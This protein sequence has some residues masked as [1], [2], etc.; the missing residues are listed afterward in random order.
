[1]KKI[2][3]FS[4]II[5][6]LGAG[7]LTYMRWVKG[8]DITLWSF[9]PQNSAVVY[10]SSNLLAAFKEIQQTNIWDN[11]S[12]IPEFARLTEDLLQ[13]DTI[14]GRGNFSEF[15]N[16]CPALIAL[17]VTS[18]QTF[19]FLYIL[20]IQNLSQQTYI[21]KAQAYFEKRGYKKQTREYEDFTITELVAPEPGK[22]FTYIY[23]RNYI[24]GSFS[25]FL[26]EDAIRTLAEDAQQ[27]FEHTHPELQTLVKLEKDHGNLYINTS[28]LTA[29]LNTFTTEQSA[30]SFA[31]STFLDVKTGTDAVN[32]SG[33]TF[34]DKST[35]FLTSFSHSSGAAFDMAEIIPGNTAWLYHFSA[36]EPKTLGTSLAAYFKETNPEIN[37]YRQKL[38][39]ESDFDV[40]ATFDFIDQEIGLAV[41]ETPANSDKNELLI[42]EINDM[43]EALKFFNAVGQ[44]YMQQTGD[45]IFAEQYG[46]YEIHKFPLERFPYALLGELAND[47]KETYYLQYRNYLIFSNSLQQLKNFTHAIEDESTWTKSLRINRFLDRTNKEANFSVFINTPRAWDQLIPT[48]K[49]SWQEYFTANETSLKSLEFLALQFNT[50]DNKFYTNVTVYQPDLPKF[51]TSKQ[52]TT[53]ET[54]TLA[55]AITSKPFIVTN[56]AD[57]SREI[58]VQDS[59]HTVY[60]IDAHFKVVWSKALDEPVVGDVRQ[61]DYYNNGKLQYIFATAKTIHVVDRTGAYLPEFPKATP[62][63]VEIEH[64]G[65]IDYD[66]T[67]KYRY[68]MAD[69][70]GNVYLTDKD[71][72]LLEGWEPKAFDSPLVQAPVHRR[73]N[74]KDVIV[75]LQ[76]NGKLWQLN[77]KGDAYPGYPKETGVVINSPM[78]LKPA[79]N[80][81][82]ASVTLLNKHGELI[83]FTFS[84]NLI[85]REQLYKPDAET[86]F[87]LMKDVTGDT[88]IILR[89]SENKYEILDQDG[90]ELFQKEYFTGKPL[91]QQYYD[92]G[93]DREFIIFVDPSGA[94]LYLYD[95]HGNLLT[96]RPITASQPISMIQFDN[97]F[98][99]YKVAGRN[100]ELISISL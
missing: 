72:S 3:L 34:V 69:K 49:P 98:Q 68:A 19:D 21:T 44:R 88:Y 11:V 20:E 76:T 37:Q 80:F 15:F 100:L 43:G 96:N 54:I 71:V 89:Q 4:T 91:Y 51:S 87:T 38:Y 65:I 82:K 58:F 40:N 30:V 78:F 74:G 48:L 62:G 22:V 93:A 57:R 5:L 13:L 70:K 99:I 17:N 23:H 14:A 26:V 52:V 86:I 41:L 28:R 77:R 50:V 27:N 84:G 55:D 36:R 63:E 56:Y 9:V 29:L 42:L 39:T 12:H 83:E 45:S 7:Y 95:Q 1:M 90:R 64:F 2:L 8:G 16:T 92:L 79:N 73:I 67:K 97:Q 46:N 53:L 61:I 33:F 18:S 25:A 47:F 10:E 60:L 32:L 35:Q 85:R 59:A 24:I 66:N 6:L 81:D 31:K 94:L 75:I